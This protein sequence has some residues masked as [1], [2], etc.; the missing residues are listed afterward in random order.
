M[1][2]EHLGIF[3]KQPAQVLHQ[4]IGRLLAQKCQTKPLPH[5]TLRLLDKKRNVRIQL[6]AHDSRTVHHAQAFTILLYYI[7]KLRI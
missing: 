2:V 1:P 6:L 7:T 4:R 5:R 3:L